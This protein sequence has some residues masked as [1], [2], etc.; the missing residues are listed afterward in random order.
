MPNIGVTLW[1][2]YSDA[3]RDVPGMLLGDADAG[4]HAADA[5]ALRFSERG[6]RRV[7]LADHVDVRNGADFDLAVRQLSLVRE[8]TRIGLSVRW[9]LECDDD[10]PVSLLQH[11]Y[12]P[13]AVAQGDGGAAR[14]WRDAYRFGSLLYRKGPGF[15]HVRDARTDGAR[16]LTL[17][18]PAHLD[19]VRALDRGAPRESI[20]P[21]LA[22]GFR[23]HRLVA[24]V[25]PY[26][27]WLPF[28]LHRWP[29]TRG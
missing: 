19:A 22:N 4:E 17:G 20:S 15:V 18:R 10:F 6:A 1:R 21:T 2:E 13:T 5:S 28:R 7:D 24:E 25:G 16:R 27:W 26:L 23:K 3:A 8:L 12:P 9:V 29:D 11:L 14:R